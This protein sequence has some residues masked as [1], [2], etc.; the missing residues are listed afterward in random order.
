MDKEKPEPGCSGAVIGKGSLPVILAPA[1]SVPQFMAALTHDVRIIDYVLDAADGLF[2]S[3]Q[4]VS[5]GDLQQ[6]S[7]IYVLSPNTDAQAQI[8]GLLG[9]VLAAQATLISAGSTVE[10]LLKVIFGLFD[11]QRQQSEAYARSL[12]ELA[13]LRKQHDLMQR[14]FA[15]LEA[16]AVATQAR[17]VEVSFQNDVIDEPHEAPLLATRSDVV[18][19]TLPTASVG[20]AAV[21]LY[22]TLPTLAT[23]RA[24]ELKLEL[25]ALEHKQRVGLWSV[26]QAL[27]K[28]GW[29]TFKLGRALSGYNSTL[30]LTVSSDMPASAPIIGLGA[31]QPL[32]RYRVHGSDGG[33]ASQRSL[34]LQIWKGIPGADLPV[35][36][37]WSEAGAQ[38]TT[39][40]QADIGLGAM[41]LI[42]T[43]TASTMQ[44]KVASLLD[45]GST[46]FLHPPRTGLTVAR[47]A[48]A[49][50]AA[51][52]RISATIKLDH[53]KA[54]PTDFALVTAPAGTMELGDIE[55]GIESGDALEWSGWA[56]LQPQ[57]AQSLHLFR[58]PGERGALL[59]VFLVT[60]VQ[61]PGAN[62]FAWA[63][64]R[65]LHY[66]VPG[67]ADGSR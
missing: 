34:A 20:T 14:D 39:A 31:H 40:Y 32:A 9:P 63:K 15:A 62:S 48:S 58:E 24:G 50:S 52:E 5:I 44:F 54:R 56:T 49:A 7:A 26:P 25:W 30:K 17:A 41:E 36:E 1:G 10:G 55:Q 23:A 19:Q 3:G 37:A 12:R 2:E 11:F 67:A 45:G 65:E 18:T 51:S 4:P 60:K 27:V 28:N 42:S 64:F 47:L 66:Y 61:S 13:L 57:Q 33:P 29:N 53:E 43:T 8:K 38:A 59:D 22:F 6:S 21:S 35:P 16:A 46:L